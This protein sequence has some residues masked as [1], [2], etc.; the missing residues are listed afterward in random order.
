M[1]RLTAIAALLVGAAVG[2]DSAK[3]SVTNPN[4]KVPEIPAGRGEGTV[5]NTPAD[6]NPAADNAN[7]K[8]AEKAGEK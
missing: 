4:M 5:P 7:E 2:C 6:Q 3:D 1:I 8:P